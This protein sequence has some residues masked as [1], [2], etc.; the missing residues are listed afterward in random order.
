[1]NAGEQRGLAMETKTA[2]PAVTT[3]PVRPG[4]TAQS[5]VEFCRIPDLARTHGIKRG[6]AYSLIN[7]GLIKSVVLRR[8]GAKTG[9]RLVHLKSVREY[10]N[11]HLT[12]T[13]G[14]AK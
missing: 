3:S 9:V 13:A 7:S 1:M 11:A 4:D 5:E 12:N 8:E 10:L 2:S 14:E 6:L